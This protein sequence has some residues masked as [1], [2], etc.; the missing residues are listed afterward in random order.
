MDIT[1]T[2]NED[3]IVTAIK[4]FLDT[5][6]VPTAGKEV[7]VQMVAGRGTNG[8]S[9]VITVK[10]E[11]P[12]A[13]EQP[14]VKRTRKAAEKPAETAPEVV[15]PVVTATTITVAPPAELF[16][17]AIV[18]ED[19]PFDE[20]IITEGGEPEDMFSEPAAP[21]APPAEVESLFS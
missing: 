5:Q 1:I 2:M 6:D 20:N 21:V 19:P 9:A 18:E 13:P 8:H 4:D 7:E 16:A 10:K 17:D 11:E 12:A 14:V 15:A 3:E